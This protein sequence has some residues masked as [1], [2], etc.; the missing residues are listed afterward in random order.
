MN[1][2]EEKGAHGHKSQ[3][4]VLTHFRTLSKDG[5]IPKQSRF[6][7][8]VDAATKTDVADDEW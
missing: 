3:D 6:D 8:K 1:K 4:D 2:P 5:Y 7:A